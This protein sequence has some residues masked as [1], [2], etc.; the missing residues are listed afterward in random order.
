MRHFSKRGT[1]LLLVAVA[2]LAIFSKVNGADHPPVANCKV[3]DKETGACTECE[4]EFFLNKA[5]NKCLT[6]SETL[7]GCQKCIMS[8][9]DAKV[10]CEKC[11]PT[12]LLDPK[13]GTC[14]ACGNF[15][16]Q[17]AECSDKS[18]CTKCQ[19]HAYLKPLLN[20]CISCSSL[21]G[22][23]A[24]CT[25]ADTCTKCATERFIPYQKN[26]LDCSMEIQ[27]CSKCTGKK[28]DGLICTE[29][30][31]STFLEEKACKACS[32][33]VPNCVNCISKDEC[34]L[35]GDSHYV[36][37]QKK[38]D[39]CMNSLP[40]CNICSD[41]KTCTTCASKHFLSTAEGVTGCK[42]CSEQITNCIDCDN[43]GHCFKCDSEHVL[44][45]KG[46]CVNCGE[47]F[48]G[49]TACQNSICSSCQDGL[50]LSAEA[51]CTACPS[52]CLKCSSAEGCTVCA[53]FHGGVGTSCI[54]Y[55]WPIVIFAFLLAFGFGL[56]FYNAR[57]VSYEDLY[58]NAEQNDGDILSTSKSLQDPLNAGGK[59]SKK[60]R[61]VDEEED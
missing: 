22:N 51:K 59:S 52:N 23:C 7:T 25:D 6:C 50:F 57:K 33:G 60:K 2:I 45:L 1:K 3:Q 55:W 26:C 53:P 44:N 11:A 34:T 58:T 17:C 27:N 54:S 56:Y 10:T 40:N 5:A 35:C 41:A 12:H 8:E 16:S 15:I 32:F 42:L 49:C 18:T 38:C 19:S 47:A 61:F 24:E 39:K 43:N 36:T 30:S 29:C 13:A 48:L 14:E 31:A 21:N 28:E 37:E 4:A 9:P 46:S 20:T